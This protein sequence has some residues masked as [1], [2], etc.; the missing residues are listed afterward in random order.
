MKAVSLGISL[1]VSAILVVSAAL[2]LV[3]KIGSDSPSAVDK[4]GKPKLDAEP[5][6]AMQTLEKFKQAVLKHDTKDMSDL[7][8]DDFGATRGTSKSEL[9][10]Q[11]EFDA[12]NN[13]LPVEID[14][15]QATL[16]TVESGLHMVR[17]NNIGLRRESEETIRYEMILRRYGDKWLIWNIASRQ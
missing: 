8:A 9:K 16:V 5:D 7:V 15:S 10:K 1:L 3:F 17:A 13:N 12:Q 4:G 11:F 14:L 2:Y 6:Q